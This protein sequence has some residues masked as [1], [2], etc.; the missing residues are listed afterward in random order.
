MSPECH[1]FVSLC[2]VCRERKGKE[3]R[4]LA[5]AASLPSAFSSRMQRLFGIRCRG[6]CTCV[7][8]FPSGSVRGVCCW[9]E[10]G[11]HF[12]LA[13]ASDIC[14][15]DNAA[16]HPSR[17]KPILGTG[18]GR[19]AWASPRHSPRLAAIRARFIALQ[20]D[21]LAGTVKCSKIPNF[22][23][24]LTIASGYVS[25]AFARCRDKYKMHYMQAAVIAEIPWLKHLH[26]RL[27][28]R[29]YVSRQSLRGLSWPFSPP[30]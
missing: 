25:I 5:Y 21:S 3:S 18:G 9:G 29:P 28:N 20:V 24:V 12:S 22:T 19:R 6:H 30:R 10:G 14:G 13:L 16:R 26:K 17:E 8:Q 11:G 1:K 2:C 27:A 23:A 15:A 7:V 4:S